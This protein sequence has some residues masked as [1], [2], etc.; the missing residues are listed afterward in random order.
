MFDTDR[1]ST[2]TRRHHAV[3]IRTQHGGTIVPVALVLVLAVAAVALRPN[4]AQLCAK[5]EDF[6]CGP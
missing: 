5:L 3:V 6:P 4:T 2:E 1:Q